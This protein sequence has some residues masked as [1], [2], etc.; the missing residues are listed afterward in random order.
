[1][2]SEYG[3]SKKDILEHTYLDELVHLLDKIKAR[4]VTEYQMQLAIIQNPHT[5]NPQELWRTL[6]QTTHK[7]IDEKPDKQG[8]MNLKRKMAGTSRGFA[9]K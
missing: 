9:V 3:W 1:M 4:Q 6:E 7:P 5:K 8:M 2:A